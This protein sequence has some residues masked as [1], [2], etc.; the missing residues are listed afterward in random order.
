[1]DVLIDT[2]ILLWTQEGNPALPQ[3]IKEILLDS[4][5]RKWVSQISFIE[6]AIKLKLGKLPAFVV[7]I[8]QLIDQAQQ[9]GFNEL[10]IA[11]KHISAY[12]QVPFFEQHRDPFDR[13]ILATALTE[14]WP[15]I[16][17][18]EKFQLYREVVKVIW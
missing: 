10:P 12:E 4:T 3:H 8:E 18:D 11:N 15:V 7:S 2:Q 17:A 14:N 6:V 16:S 5:S 9:D 13:L 1:M